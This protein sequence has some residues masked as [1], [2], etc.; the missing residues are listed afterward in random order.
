MKDHFFY[1]FGFNKHS[2]LAVSYMVFLSACTSVAVENSQT[3]SHVSKEEAKPALAFNPDLPPLPIEKTGI[4]E[5]LPEAF[6]ESWVYVDESSFFSMFGGKIIVLDV[7]ETKH[8]ERIKGTADK[9]LL[10]NFVAAKTRNEFYIMESFHERGSRGPRTDVLAIYDKTTMAPIKELVWTDTTRLTA[11]PERFAMTLSGD[12][13]FLFVANFSPAASFTVVDLDTHEIVE[14]IGTPGCVLTYPTGNRSVSSL[15]SNGGMLTTVVDNQGRKKS[16]KRLAPFFDTDD[17]PI[18]ER[19][20]IVEGIA[21]F[22]SF[23]GRIHAIDMRGETA[24]YIENWSLVSDKEKTEHWRP[25]GLVLNDSDEQGLYYVIMNPG[26]HD[27]SQTHGGQYVWVFDLKTKKRLRTIEVPNWALSIAL[28]RGKKPSMVI[29]NGE[30]NLD[31]IN[32]ET[33]ELI[34]TISDFGNVTPLL[35]NKAY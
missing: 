9:N 34:Q 10:G 22:P 31:V 27:G 26:G 21:Y 12:E 23:K 29:T 8:S 28:T 25:S 3:Q 1:K 16:Q 35:I 5:V 19:P 4:I 6:P 32:P 14:T 13:R 7:K 20:V 15:C 11:L 30:L 33:G 24:K 18:F 17:T 2:L